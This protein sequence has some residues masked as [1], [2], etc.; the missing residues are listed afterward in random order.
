LAPPPHLP[1]REPS[2]M[3]PPPRP[4]PFVPSPTATT[5]P[6]QDAAGKM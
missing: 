4:P 1:P 3:M 2:P 6:A 5:V